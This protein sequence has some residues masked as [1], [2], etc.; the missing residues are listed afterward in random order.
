LKGAPEIVL[1]MCAIDSQEKNRLLGLIDEW[2]RSGL[3]LL[4]LAWRPDANYAEHTQYRWLGLIALE[5]P[6]REV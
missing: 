6:V 1:G 3:R 4:G 2:A 5:D